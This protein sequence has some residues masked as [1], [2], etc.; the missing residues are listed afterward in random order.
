MIKE[1]YLTG[2]SVV[3]DRVEQGNA[4]PFTL[5]FVHQLHLRFESLVTFFVGENGTGKSTL[6]EA[7][8]SLC[9]CPFRAAVA[10]S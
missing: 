1:P 5:P 7:I 6:I 8:A 4:Y 10:T 2:V 9:G 3:P